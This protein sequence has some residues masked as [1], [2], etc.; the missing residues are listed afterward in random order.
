MVL[1]LPAFEAAGRNS[2][3]F[4]SLGSKKLVMLGSP[5]CSV[6]LSPP[7]FAPPPD[8]LLFIHLSTSSGHPY[9][10]HGIPFVPINPERLEAAEGRE[11]ED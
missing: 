11:L 8:V 7:P 2:S 6:W 5:A 10:R 9:G 4:S 1:G 3:L